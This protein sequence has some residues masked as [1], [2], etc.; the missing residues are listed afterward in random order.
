V[1]PPLR[2]IQSGFGACL[3]AAGIWEWLRKSWLELGRFGIWWQQSQELNPEQKSSGGEAYLSL[4]SQLFCSM[5][6]RTGLLSVSI[7]LIFRPK[8][9]SLGF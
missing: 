8:L 4:V 3:K 6:E 9:F 1:P 7:S 2:A 5:M